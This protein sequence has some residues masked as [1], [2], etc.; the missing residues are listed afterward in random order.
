MSEEDKEELITRLEKVVQKLEDVVEK[1][2]KTVYLVIDSADRESRNLI[3]VFSSKESVIKAIDKIGSYYAWLN[4][5]GDVE[6]NADY[7]IVSVTL[8]ETQEEY[9]SI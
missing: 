1:T 2:E 8:D 7:N 5:N 4:K 6:T 3:G 9:F